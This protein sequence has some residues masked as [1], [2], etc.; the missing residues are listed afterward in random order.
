MSN[1]RLCCH[2]AWRQKQLFNMF[3]STIYL[4]AKTV[5]SM[6]ICCLLLISVVQPDL[7]FGDTKRNY[8]VEAAFIY[9]FLNF[10]EWPPQAFHN[11]DNTL[12]IG[13]VGPNPF[14]DFFKPVE[15]Q[16]VGDRILVVRHFSIETSLVDLKQC[17]LLYVS[18]ELKHKIPNIISSLADYPVLTVSEF[19]KFIYQG[20]MIALYMK[21]NKVKFAINRTAAARAGVSFRA[22]LLRVADKVYTENHD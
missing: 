17:Q 13:I 10:T 3:S 12:T 16:P 7:A 14:D 5:R 8:Q 21:E 20:G 11:S 1:L 6:L 4:T 19:E 18:Q 2:V 9:Q 22:R 15:G